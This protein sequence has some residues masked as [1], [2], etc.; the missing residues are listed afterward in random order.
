MGLE[1]SATTT[2]FGP[3]VRPTDEALRRLVDGEFSGGYLDG[4]FAILCE[5]DDNAPTITIE[6]RDENDIALARSD[7][8][9]IDAWPRTIQVETWIRIYLTIESA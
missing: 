1:K 9:P 5:R 3:T 6:I 4:K 7:A 8:I 2:M